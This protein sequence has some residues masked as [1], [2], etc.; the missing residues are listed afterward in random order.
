MDIRGVYDKKERQ[1]TAK[2][3]RKYA[4]RMKIVGDYEPRFAPRIAEQTLGELFLGQKDVYAF[5]PKKTAGQVWNEFHNAIEKRAGELTE[6]FVSAVRQG[7][8]QNVELV[9]LPVYFHI[10]KKQYNAEKDYEIIGRWGPYYYSPITQEESTVD[11][12]RNFLGGKGGVISEE[13]ACKAYYRT[14]EERDEQDLEDLQTIASAKVWELPDWKHHPC[15][16]DGFEITEQKILQTLLFP[17]WIIRVGYQDGYYHY[18]SDVSETQPINLPKTKAWREKTEARL[19]QL[20]AV[21][22]PLQEASKA[23]F[24]VAA[25]LGVLAL[26]FHFFAGKTEA[27]AAYASQTFLGFLPVF[28]ALWAG[29]KWLAPRMPF[30]KDTQFWRTE[31]ELSSLQK[32]SKKGYVIRFA[33]YALLVVLLA[34]MMIVDLCICWPFVFAI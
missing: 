7:G 27:G 20:N 18:A 13:K 29:K 1:E 31:L 12:F 34:A 22:S 32:Q 25:V 28:A 30:L 16:V 2:K 8:E 23:L 3:R 17:L 19:N 15:L 14:D 6:E 5:K 4:Q 33:L 26:I 21:C 11:F 24:W 9:Y 10:V